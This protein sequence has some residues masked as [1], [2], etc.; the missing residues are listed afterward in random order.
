MLARA[1]WKHKDPT[2]A[3]GVPGSSPSSTNLMSGLEQAISPS[4]ASNC[5][6]CLWEWQLMEEVSPSSGCPLS[7]ATQIPW[8]KS[9]RVEQGLAAWGG[10]G[11]MKGE[12]TQG[13]QV[14]S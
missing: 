4:W 10:S 14:W 7:S 1:A 3:P 11:A 9:V 5:Q 6:M 13:G 12:C 2:C 8:A